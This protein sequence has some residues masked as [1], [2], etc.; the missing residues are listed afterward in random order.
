MKPIQFLYKQHEI[1]FLH[2]ENSVMVNATHMAKVYDKRLDHF[3]RTDNTK[4]FIKELE[5]TLFG[6]NSETLKQRRNY[7]RVTIKTNTHLL[8]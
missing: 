3:L 8:T 1:A 2:S 7:K 6:V 5:F 4:T